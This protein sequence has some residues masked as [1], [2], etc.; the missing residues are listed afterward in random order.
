MAEFQE[1][2]LGN[3]DLVV[4]R[5]GFGTYHLLDAFD[6]DMASASRA[7]VEAWNAGIDLIDT[8]DNYPGS[9]EA[10]RQ[11]LQTG[12]SREH[13]TIATK[14]GLATSFSEHQQW[15]SE[16]KNTDCSPERAKSQLRASLG[17]L[18]INEVDL[19]QYHRY[20]SRV[21]HA[22]AAGAMSDFI[23][24]GLVRAWGVSNYSAEELAELLAVC[25][26][27]GLPRPVT[28]QPYLNFLAGNGKNARVAQEAGMTVLAYGPLMK[29]LLTD[30]G[31][32]QASVLIERMAADKDED[33]RMAAE[34]LREPMKDM[35]LLQRRAGEMGVNLAQ[36]A[37]AIV[38]DQP[39]T[40][41][42]TAARKP[43]YLQDV[44]RAEVVELDF[45]QELAD[46]IARLQASP[47]AESGPNIMQFAKT[48]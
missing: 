26:E 6:G 35:R 33:L 3:S 8:S 46:V 21:P 29:G 39:N 12:I 18:G 11:A 47:L 45:D 42:L 40:A 31:V 22:E 20:D 2:Q 30:A 24:A 36:L 38:A 5:F 41:V 13:A 4:S 19:Y 23:E 7:I 27:E 48:V 17:R 1:I 34:L 32:E 10:I 25:D 37:L 43:E 14:T 28:S 44:V 16:G 15:E 9:E